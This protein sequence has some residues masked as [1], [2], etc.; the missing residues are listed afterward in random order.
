MRSKDIDNG[1]HIDGRD[2]DDDYSTIA[3]MTMALR[4]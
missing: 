3:I 4:R 2:D 1:D